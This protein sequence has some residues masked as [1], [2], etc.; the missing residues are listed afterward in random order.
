MGLGWAQN[1]AR[2]AKHFTFSVL[3]PSP[4]SSFD[5]NLFIQVSKCTSSSLLGRIDSN[6]SVNYSCH[7]LI[8][9]KTAL[10]D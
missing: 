8:V 3:Y 5:H 2:G 4:P 9:R 6:F 10:F 7:M 1:D